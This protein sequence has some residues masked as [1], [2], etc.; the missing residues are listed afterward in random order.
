MDCNLQNWRES[1]K[2]KAGIGRFQNSPISPPAKIKS[3]K[4]AKMGAMKAKRATKK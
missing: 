3:L 4:L 2:A 1:L